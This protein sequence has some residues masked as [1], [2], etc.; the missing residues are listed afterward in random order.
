MLARLEDSVLVVVDV[1]PSVF[2][3]VVNKSQVFERIGFIVRCAQV[4]DVPILWTEQEPG[5]LGATEP[6][7]VTLMSETKPITK[8]SFSCWRE[9]QFVQAYNML[10]RAQ[11]VLVGI[12]THICVNQTA[13]DLLDEDF[14]VIVC[15]DAVSARTELAH[16]GG[17]RRMADEGAA[18]AHTES[19]VYEWMS[20]S[21]HPRFR[22]VLSL[23]KGT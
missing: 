11:A 1:Q 6:N 7:L 16:E 2:N 13:H 9:K 3:L 17:L 22:E 20:S 23:V 21:T 8:S 15:A 14:D 18:I 19:V 4:L 5:K 10:Q 12:E